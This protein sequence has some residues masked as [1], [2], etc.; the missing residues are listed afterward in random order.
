MLF[1]VNV[2]T[3]KV[4]NYSNCTMYT[5]Q[6]D[7][8]YCMGTSKNIS[9]GGL[10][11]TLKPASEFKNDKKKAKSWLAQSGECI[12]SATLPVV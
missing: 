9:F 2:P 3:N 11:Q 7:F 6:L 8:N 12:S 1:E 5:R 10:L 4:N